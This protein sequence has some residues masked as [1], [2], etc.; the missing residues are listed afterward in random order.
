MEHQKE[1]LNKAINHYQKH[2]KGVLEMACG[3]G[4]TFVSKKI[5]KS[6]LPKG[7]LI[8]YFIPWLSLL[9]QSMNYFNDAETLTIPVYSTQADIITKKKKNKE[10]DVILSPIIDLSMLLNSK[11]LEQYRQK[12]KYIIIF[13]TYK[14]IDKLIEK[15]QTQLLPKADFIICDEAHHTVSNKSFEDTSDDNQKDISNDDL[16]QKLKAHRKLFMTATVKIYR[17]SRKNEKL[18]FYDMDNKEF[19]GIRF[20]SL[21]LG[22]AIEKDILCDYGVVV[23]R[24]DDLKEAQTI[25]DKLDVEDKK[26]DDLHKKKFR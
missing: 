10:T 23:A 20:Y 3:T 16:H 1:A 21:V 24:F 9:E 26:I 2:D 18:D 22:T 5:M 6:L 8:F 19:Y 17:H 14:S 25:L 13:C 15:Q 4:K 12:Y 11:D 7:G